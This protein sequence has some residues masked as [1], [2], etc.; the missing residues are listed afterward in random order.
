MAERK[1]FFPL[2]VF[3]DEI[4]LDSQYRELLIARILGM[5]DQTPPENPRIT[6]SGDSMGFGFLHQ[7]RNF[8]GLFEKL[9]G[10]VNRYLSA[11][12]VI[13]E[14]FN[15]YFTRSW[16]EVAHKKEVM[17]LHKHIQSHI[18]AI[19][20]LKKP[21]NSGGL[22][23]W[24][25]HAQNEF[26]VKLFTQKMGEPG[27]ADHPALLDANDLNLD[28]AEGDVLVF[29][30]KTEHSTM[31]SLSDEERISIAIDVIVTLRDSTFA[32]FGLPDIRN[33]KRY[34]DEDLSVPEREV[35]TS[36]G[37]PSG[38]AE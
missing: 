38:I 18:S 24:R 14:K 34:G 10:S 4:L 27:T 11:L 36:L 28:L 33:W 13:P 5:R 6:W 20:Y 19:Y 26:M 32:E 12:N 22:I 35:E 7:D 29:P 21:V 17:G 30:S 1:D 37:V 8:D 31:P 2:T 3:K 16:A 25:A 15:L 23:F 9:S